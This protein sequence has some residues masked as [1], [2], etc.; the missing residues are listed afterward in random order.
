MTRILK[1]V[2]LAAVCAVAVQANA[3]TKEEIK[4]ST[5]ALVEFLEK[6][7]YKRA[8]EE[9]DFL[10]QAIREMDGLA[11]KKF[12]LD[13]LAGY[14]G[15][16][17]SVQNAMGVQ[18]IERT[19]TKD[20]E[21]VKVTLTGMGGGGGMAGLAALGQMFGQQQGAFRLPG[22]I[23]ANIA[24]QGKSHTVTATIGKSMFQAQS[25][26]ASAESV[27]SVSQAF[28]TAELLDY[29]EGR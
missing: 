17:I 25:N 5:D 20:G 13:E 1:A 8:Q 22:R 11:K 16:E 27:K 28:P 10:G 7:D 9:L 12:F 19:Y 15:G 24:S 4:E 14:T 6:E 23:P 18:V 2:C 29:E 26:N 3:A 21:S